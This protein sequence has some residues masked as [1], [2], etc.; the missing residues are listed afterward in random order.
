MAFSIGGWAKAHTH[1][2]LVGVGE[3]PNTP[4]TIAYHFELA[5][6][7]ASTSPVMQAPTGIAWGRAIVRQK[8]FVSGT[9]SVGPIYELQVAYDSGF[10]SQLRT[11]AIAYARRVADDETFLMAGVVP[12]AQTYTFARIAATYSQN[13][14][15]TFDALV[16]LLPGV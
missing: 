10:T 14:G 15:S 5:D 7:N 9:G 8:G 13:D 12:D 1:P 6:Q 2:F 11:I 4:P 16:D 3:A